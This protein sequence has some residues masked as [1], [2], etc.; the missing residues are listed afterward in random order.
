MANAGEKARAN[1]RTQ[2]LK[3]AVKAVSRLIDPLLNRGER[4]A[5]IQLETLEMLKLEAACKAATAR[6]IM[7]ST[8]RCN[9]KLERQ[10]GSVLRPTTALRP[11]MRNQEDGCWSAS[12]GDVHGVGP[13]PEL[14]CQDFD[15]KWLGKDEL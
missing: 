12:Y 14:A 13:T 4:F 6:D 9:E 10:A 3:V 8:K 7:E 11:E 5:A 15:R 1:A 2:D